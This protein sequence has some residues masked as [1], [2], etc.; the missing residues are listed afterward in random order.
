MISDKQVEDIMKTPAMNLLASVAASVNPRPGDEF[1]QFDQSGN[2]FYTH[3]VAV[4]EVRD[5][6]VSYRN[7]DLLAPAFTSLSSCRLDVFGRSYE[8]T[9]ETVEARKHGVTLPDYKAYLDDMRQQAEDEA[10]ELE[11]QNVRYAEK[12]ELEGATEK[13]VQRHEETANR[14]AREYRHANPQD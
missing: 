14:E 8:P 13:E 5:G 6:W 11:E 10:K 3:R 4:I 2:P 12:R 7:F 1:T 9:K